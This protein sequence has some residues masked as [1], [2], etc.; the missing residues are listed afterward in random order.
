MKKKLKSI[1]DKFFNEKLLKF[2]YGCFFFGVGACVCAFVALGIFVLFLEPRPNP[3]DCVNFEAI[4][5]SMNLPENTSIASQSPIENTCE[6]TLEV[7]QGRYTYYVGNNFV[8]EG[9]MVLKP[10]EY[11]SR[12]KEAPL[13]PKKKFKKLAQTNTDSK[14]INLN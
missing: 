7:N 14:N 8:I 3:C 4:K 11:S 5:T 12:E 2:G 9:Q 10:G 6:V 1:K 13:K